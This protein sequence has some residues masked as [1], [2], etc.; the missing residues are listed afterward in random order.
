MRLF[1]EGTALHGYFDLFIISV[2]KTGVS[3]ASTH[4]LIDDNTLVVAFHV[5][6]IVLVSL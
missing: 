1:T 2:P 4:E 6:R 3:E 5:H